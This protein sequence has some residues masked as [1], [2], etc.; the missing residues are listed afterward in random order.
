MYSCDIQIVT[1]PDCCPA[2]SVSEKS[3]IGHRTVSETK[4]LPYF[5]MIFGVKVPKNS[6]VDNKDL[7]LGLVNEY[8]S[9]QFGF[10]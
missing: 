3:R 8:L 7:S 1:I 10:I 2:H 6:N 9:A 5:R 4:L